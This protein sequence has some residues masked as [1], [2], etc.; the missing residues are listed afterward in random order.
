MSQQGIIEITLDNGVYKP[1]VIQGAV[2]Q[3]LRLKFIRKDASHCA[4]QVIFDD[5]NVRQTLSLEQP[6]EVELKLDKVGEFSFSCAMGMYRG[7][8]IVMSSP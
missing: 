4:D 2:G 5:F 3:T 1:N 8:L 7:Q 6:T